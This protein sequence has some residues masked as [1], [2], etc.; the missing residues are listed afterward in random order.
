MWA[1]QQAAQK[2]WAGNAAVGEEG[3]AP[4]GRVALQWLLVFSE[5]PLWLRGTFALNA[6]NCMM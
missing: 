2:S 4:G 1:A 5:G 3:A 6:L